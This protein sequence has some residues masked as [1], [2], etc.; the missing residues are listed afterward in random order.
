MILHYEG[1]EEANGSV[2]QLVGGPLEEVYVLVRFYVLVLH[3]FGYQ[4]LMRWF[5]CL[6][7]L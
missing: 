3:P 4:N 2:Q 6:A 1:K 5:A 7:F